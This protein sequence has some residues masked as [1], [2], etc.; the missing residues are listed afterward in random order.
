MRKLLA[1]GVCVSIFLCLFAGQVLAAQDDIVVTATI[2]PNATTVHTAISVAPTSFPLQQETVVTVTIQ[3]SATYVGSFPLT[4]QG[5][6]GEGTLDTQS[7]PTIHSAEY[8]AASASTGY[9]GAVPV[10]DLNQRTVTWHIASFSSAASPQT[11]SFQIKTTS[12]YTGPLTVS[13]PVE[14]SIL[15]PVT[16]PIA[17]KTIE[18]KYVFA[19]VSTATPTPSSDSSAT[20][21]VSPLSVAETTVSPTPLPTA[22]SQISVIK[23]VAVQSTGAHI[24]IGFSAPS[25]AVIEYGTHYDA[26]TSRKRYR[27][28]LKTHT[29][30]LTD[31]LPQT[32]YYFRVR[33]VDTGL[34]LSEVYTFTTAGNEQPFT[35]EKDS[36]LSLVITRKGTVIAQDLVLGNREFVSTVPVAKNSIIDVYLEVPDATDIA[37]ITAAIRVKGVLGIVSDVLAQ[38]ETVS[39]VSHL[40]KIGDTHY[41]VKLKVPAESG[42]YELVGQ[43]TYLS[44]GFQEQV[45]SHLEIKNSFTVLDG[46]TTEPLENATVYIERFNTNTQLF[47]PFPEMYGLSHNPAFTGTDGT[48]DVTLLSGKYRARVSHFTY[49]DTVVEFLVSLDNTVALPTVILQPKYGAFITFFAHTVPVITALLRE[50]W[51]YC[52]SLSYSKQLLHFL[53]LGMGINCAAAIVYVWFIYH[54]PAFQLSELMYFHR[55]RMRTEF[56]SLILFVLLKLVFWIAE[57]GMMISMVYAYLFSLSFGL[58]VGLTLG[59]LCLTTFTLYVSCEVIAAYLRHRKNRSECP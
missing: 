7:M 42:Q 40:T 29:V 23:L 32:Q 43:L 44:G 50:V 47:E 5:S 38:E 33:A 53:L 21:T 2:S 37:D 15:S 18:Y 1:L 13:F 48:L 3:Y 6:W 46:R 30:F 19:P 31:L 52:M 59:I 41:S 28:L 10:V 34:P 4:L 16:S 45:L 8:V 17:S 39:S 26:L 51:Q 12:A 9:G 20:P 25:A 35:Q 24:G 27:D 49:E 11:V 36:P 22:V 14:A 57:T 58:R 56:I 55:K 54:Y